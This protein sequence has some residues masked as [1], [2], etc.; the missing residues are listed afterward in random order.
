MKAERDGELYARRE[1]FGEEDGV[2]FEA[3]FYRGG[4]SRL[5]RPCV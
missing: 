5:I 3:G 2:E 4:W 1:L